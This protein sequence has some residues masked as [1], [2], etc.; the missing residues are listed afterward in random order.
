[1]A[2]KKDL[3]V[4]NLNT[5]IFMF[6]LPI[7]ISNLFQAMYNAVDMYFVGKY[8]TTAS[9]AAVSVSGPIMNVLLMA[10]SGMALGVTIILG[11]L[12]G[13]GDNQRIKKTANTAIVIFLISSVILSVLGIAL[14]PAILKIV[15]TPKEAFSQALSYLRIVFAGM[16]FT[17][18]YN[19]VCAIQR[20]FGDSKSSMYFVLASTI[21]NIVLDY[22]FIAV[23]NAGVEG[24]AYATVI[25]QGVSF[26]LSIIYFRRKKHIVTFSPRDFCFDKKTAGEIIKIGLPSAFQQATVNIA[27]VALNGIVNSYGLYASA[28][29]GICVKLDSFAVLP[30]SAVNDAVSAVSSQ[31]LGVGQKE[32]AIKGITVGRKILI[33]FNILLMA[34]MF[35]LG[36]KL[37]CLFNSDPNVIY[38]AHRYIKISCIMYIFYAIYYPLMGFIKGTGNAVFTLLNTIAAQLIIRVPVAYFCAKILGLGFYGAAVAWIIAPIFSNTVYTIYLKSGKWDKSSKTHI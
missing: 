1:M 2:L 6:A 11:R 22:I 27:Y 10:V 5:Q 33:P 17:L 21:T 32:R 13:T 18:G 7:I 30:C 3:T 36:G 9:T 34:V 4:G 25:S 31:N 38:M 28:A 16:I 15:Y 14:S 20:G 29:Y 37:V 23:L 35:F 8:L 26:V 24:A 12:V 19:L